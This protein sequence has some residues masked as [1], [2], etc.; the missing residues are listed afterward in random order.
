MASACCGALE[1]AHLPQ[2]NHELGLQA[3]CALR[4]SGRLYLA[5]SQIISLA[6]PHLASLVALQHGGQ[7]CQWLETK[8][9]VVSLLPEEPSPLTAGVHAASPEFPAFLAHLYR[10]RG[11]QVGRRP[12]AAARRQRHPTLVGGG[13]A[14]ACPISHCMFCHS[15][16][17]S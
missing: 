15:T 14:L 2:G 8:L 5:H 4:F 11:F 1:V 16:C 3:D 6:S 10:E 9:P 12:A 17:L 13:L 7:N